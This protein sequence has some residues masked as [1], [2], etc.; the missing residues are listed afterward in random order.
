MSEYNSSFIVSRRRALARIVGGVIGAAIAAGVGGYF[1]GS[2]IGRGEKTVTLTQRGSEVT[3]TV[4]STVR[5]VVT[6]TVRA[7]PV[8]LSVRITTTQGGIGL[9]PYHLIIQRYLDGGQEMAKKLGLRVDAFNVVRGTGEAMKELLEGRADVI[10]GVNVIEAARQVEETKGEVKIFYFCEYGNYVSLVVAPNSQYKSIE[11]L[12]RVV[13]EGKRLKVGFSR[14]GSLTHAYVYILSTI[15]GTEIGKGIEAVSLGEFD[16]IVAALNRGEIDCF[17][18]SVSRTFSL[19][20]TGKGKIIYYF[21]EFLGT[22]WHDLCHV[23]TTSYLQKNKETVRRFVSYWREAVR[24]WMLNPE[25]SISLMKADPPKG[26][27]LT[28]SAAKRWYNTL[29]PNP[30]GAPNTDALKEIEKYG[31]L[32]GLLKNPP[33]VEQWYTTEYL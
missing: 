21:N 24:A 2:S 4:F 1:V 12:R 3:R 13:R 5:E 16:A 25:L 31:K 8:P 18:W 10:T 9:A 22:K 7:E 33:P 15:L 14:P 19:E 6:T 26:L 29:V 27:G 32:I 23:S 28:D 30:L 17:P 20:E 11:D